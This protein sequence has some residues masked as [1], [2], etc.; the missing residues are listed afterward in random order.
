MRTL[1]IGDVHGSA[2][3]LDA[4][5]LA[6]APAPADRLVFLGDYVDRGPDTRGVLDRLIRLRAKFPHAVFLRGNHEVMM[7]R[8]RNSSWERRMWL[9]V[10]GRETLESYS[11]A[12]GA[13][14]RMDDVPLEHWEFL[15]RHLVD[16]YETETNLFVHACLAPNLPLDQQPEELLFWEFLSPRWAVPHPSGKRVICGHTSQKDGCV[17]DLGHTICIDTFIYGGGWLTALDVD[18]LRFWQ[19]DER[20]RVRDGHLDPR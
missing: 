2:T 15:T 4:L 1:A 12:P 5:L 14:S 3:A 8:S 17:L 20:G 9:Q 19:A 7:T 10:G 16:Y 18:S 11:D 13:G 6:I